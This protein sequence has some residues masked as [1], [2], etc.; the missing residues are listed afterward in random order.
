MT[1]VIGWAAG[2]RRLLR[3]P[4][5]HPADRRADP[6]GALLRLES[7]SAARGR[8]SPT[9]TPARGA[10]ARGA[11]PRRR[12]CCGGGRRPRGAAPGQRARSACGRG[13]AVDGRRRVAGAAGPAAVRRGV[14]RPAVRR[15]PTRP[16]SAGRPGWLAAGRGARRRARRRG[17][18]AG[19]T[20][21]TPCGTA[22][23]G[24]PPSGTVADHDRA[25]CPG[26]FDPVTNGHLDII[27]RAAALRRGRRGGRHQP[28]KRRLFE[29][30]SAWT[31]SARSPPTSATS[32][33]QVPRP[34]RRL[35]SQHDIPVIV[36][37]LR[38]VSDFDYELQM[39]QM[40]HGL[41]GI[42][43]LFMP[44]NPL[45]SFLSSSLV[46]EV[47]TWGGDVSGLVPERCCARLANAS[48]ARLTVA[49]A[50]PETP[51]PGSPACGHWPQDRPAERGMTVDVQAKLD[52]IAALIEGARAM[53]MSASCIVNRGELLDLLD[54]LRALLP[55]ELDQA[56]RSS[57]PRRG[58]RRGP[59]RGRGDHR[60]ARAERR[61]SCPRPRSSRRRAR[62]RADP[63]RRRRRPSGSSRGRRLRRRQA[64]QL[65]G[66]AP[67]DPAGGGAGPQKLR[68]ND[69][70]RLVGRR[71]GRAACRLSPG[72]APP[73]P[74]RGP[75]AASAA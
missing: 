69:D 66:G 35:L 45:Y 4:A 46:K 67:Q 31:C 1:R 50:G 63:R 49:D 16:G 51:A 2:G 9:S 27:G 25:V 74:V 58:G 19:R 60:G 33:R 13:R 48:R 12:P 11:V 28:A 20:V 42:E 64:G 6:R 73:P 18:A 24:T 62:G 17:R 3:P 37:G 57:R 40:N 23:T 59:P 41:A 72:A 70:R 61:G 75:G 38:A 21:S 71:R 68:G 53:P 36:K 15:R 47:A 32:G 10:R 30:T 34:D 54:E 39:A 55:A 56:R 5:R 65:R 14:R 22:A 43:T 44:T 29:T 52:E 8:G 26:S 7:L